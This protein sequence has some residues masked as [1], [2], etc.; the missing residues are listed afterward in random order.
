MAGTG[1]ILFINGEAGIGKSRLVSETQE[2]FETAAPESG[3]RV[4]LEGRCVSY[5]ESL[6]YWAY[7][8]LV[9][10][11]LGAGEDDPELRVRVALR[12][13][14]DGLFGD[15][16][17]E[18]Y[19]YLGAM[20]GL[21]LEPEAAAR[22]AELSPEALQYRTFEVVGSLLE[23]LA[24][25]GPVAVVIEDL[26]W[27]DATSVQLTERLLGLTERAAV[28]FVIAQRAERD[29]ASWAGEGVGC[30]RAAA[31][32]P[33]TGPGGALGRRRARTAPR[34]RRARERCRPTSSAA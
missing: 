2:L 22:L 20:L 19:P 18:I 23:R 17:M 27:A 33:R 16:T 10:E 32:D 29:H 28:L 7:R 4:W 15:R 14:V 8:D 6:P 9:R 12:R 30:P 24:A 34:P 5:G 31:P 1:G 26:H 25:D 3:Q 13:A 21:A 11:W